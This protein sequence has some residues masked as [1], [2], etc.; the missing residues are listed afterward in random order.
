MDPFNSSHGRFCRDSRD[1][2]GTRFAV[3]K[4]NRD[5]MWF[6]GALALIVSI[7]AALV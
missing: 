2:F 6:I 7:A 1:A 3:E 5:W 4:P